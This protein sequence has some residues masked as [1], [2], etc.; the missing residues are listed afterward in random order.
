MKSSN[1]KYWLNENDFFL[2]EYQKNAE[3]YRSISQSSTKLSIFSKYKSLYICENI[4]ESERDYY[5]QLILKCEGQ[6]TSR[7]NRS[8]L[9]LCNNAECK[10]DSD[11]ARIFKNRQRPPSVSTDWILGLI[12][13]YFHSVNR[14]SY[15]LFV[16]SF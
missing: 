16:L 13:T 15:P 12:I 9:I 8:T 1:E 11:L 3:K 10:F 5:H 2:A 4:S 14:L 7:P 6:L